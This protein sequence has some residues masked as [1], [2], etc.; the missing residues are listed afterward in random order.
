MGKYLTEEWEI[1]RKLRDKKEEIVRGAQIQVGYYIIYLISNWKC[2]NKAIY[3]ILRENILPAGQW[4]V[5]GQVVSAGQRPRPGGRKTRLRLHCPAPPPIWPLHPAFPLVW[6]AFRTDLLY[7][8]L[9]ELFGFGW[10]LRFMQWSVGRQRGG[11]SRLCRRPVGFT[12]KSF[13]EGWRLP[14][15][16]SVVLRGTTRTTKHKMKGFWIISWAEA[17]EF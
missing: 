7:L 2:L 4:R 12:G 6:A 13:A 8:V 9:K 1:C 17:T 16:W 14:L 3:D 15:A 11:Q 10:D 5:S